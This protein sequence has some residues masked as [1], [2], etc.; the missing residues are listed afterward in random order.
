MIRKQ[1]V[2]ATDGSS[3][4]SA[5]ARVSW[6]LNSNIRSQAR[7]LE[8]PGIPA[9]SIAGVDLDAVARRDPEAAREIARIGERMRFGRETDAEFLA[10]IRL[11]HAAGEGARAEYLLRRNLDPGAESYTL[12]LELFGSAKEDEYRGAVR[13][14]E[15]QFG[16]SLRFLKRAQ[17]LVERYQSEAG[18][19]LA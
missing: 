9:A 14:F 17:F 16:V 15:R 1:T 10:L 8:M 3:N 18:G 2:H 7:S 12:Y 5:L 13:G 6:L 19:P 4:V 11:L